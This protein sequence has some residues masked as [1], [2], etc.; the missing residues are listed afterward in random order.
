MI[1]SNLAHEY[2]GDIPWDENPAFAFSDDAEQYLRAFKSV[3]DVI[4]VGG[5]KISFADEIWDFNPY[6]DGI[7]DDSLK[8]QFI[9]LPQP[10]AD[11]CK[12]L[13]CTVLWERKRFQP[14]MSGSLPLEAFIAIL[15]KQLHMIL[16]GLSRLKIS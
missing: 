15:Q 8:V 14:Q 6:F 12:F 9:G 10:L 7:N 13:S 1:Q 3:V 16:F 11:Y 2:V 4:P 5:G